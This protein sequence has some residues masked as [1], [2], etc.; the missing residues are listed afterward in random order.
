MRLGIAHCAE[1]LIDLPDCFRSVHGRGRTG[2]CDVSPAVKT[3]LGA[4]PDGVVPS[5]KAGLGF[6]A[7][8]SES[9]DEPPHQFPQRL[10]VY[11]NSANRRGFGLTNSAHPRQAR[12]KHPGCDIA[13]VRRR[14][15]Q[16]NQVTDDDD[17]DKAADQDFDRAE[18]RALQ[19][20]RSRS[21]QR[22]GSCCEATG[23]R[24]TM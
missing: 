11:R 22:R 4:L 5:V 8:R 6:A 3:Q 1:L 2:C 21:R 20:Q 9:A 23:C 24:T 16:L 19:A 17:P 7:G 15:D 10:S 12:N 14:D 13:P 18:T